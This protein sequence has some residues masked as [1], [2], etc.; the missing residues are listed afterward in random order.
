MWHDIINETTNTK[1]RNSNDWKNTHGKSKSLSF[2]ILA[3]AGVLY[4]VLYYIIRDLVT[5]SR[6]WVVP[7]PANWTF[8][9]P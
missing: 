1:F 6:Q 9:D 5:M 2:E 4:T 7:N 8:L 3:I